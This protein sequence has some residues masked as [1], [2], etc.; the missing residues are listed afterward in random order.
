MTFEVSDKILPLDSETCVIT[1]GMS[2]QG[3]AW[4]ELADGD[5][6]KCDVRG[7]EGQRTRKYS[8]GLAQVEG[9]GRSGSTGGGQG[10]LG[11]G[12]GHRAS[13]LGRPGRLCFLETLGTA[14]GQNSH[15]VLQVSCLVE[16]WGCCLGHQTF[17]PV[18][19]RR[20]SSRHGAEGPR[21]GL[22]PSHA[23][24]GPSPAPGL[25]HKARGLTGLQSRLIW[26]DPKYTFYQQL[27]LW[28]I[29]VLRYQ[30]PVVLKVTQF[31][32]TLS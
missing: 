22:W 30:E 6:I 12:G 19:S 4:R 32:N 28:L 17:S 25:E 2:R 16:S 10:L 20:D 18:P 26:R 11:L 7:T 29:V 27:L 21:G 31:R 13:L 15:F 1:V 9:R 24:R 5:N 14:T 3:Q 8:T 23:P